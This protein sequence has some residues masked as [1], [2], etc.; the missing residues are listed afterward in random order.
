MKAFVA[1]LTALGPLGLFAIAIIDSSGIPIP[2]AVDIL[3]IV[4][5]IASP[6]SAWLVTVAAI[7]GSLIGNF[8]LYR[9]ARKGGQLFLDRHTQGGRGAQFRRWFNHYG[10]LTVFIPALVPVPMPLKPFV[11]CSAVFGVPFRF[12]LGTILLA[13]LIRYP[14]LAYL[15]AQLGNDAPAFLKSHTP[16]LAAIAGL[17]FCVLFAAIRWLDF[18]RSHREPL[19]DIAPNAERFDLS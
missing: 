5:S 15:G 3:I 9:I 4:L 8:I 12:F 13:R 19:H 10:L 6:A 11:A 2:A 16:H 17:L 7:T 18:R 1:K 14:A